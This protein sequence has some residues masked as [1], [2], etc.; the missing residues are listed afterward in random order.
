M[1]QYSYSLPLKPEELPTSIVRINDIWRVCKRYLLNKT[2]IHLDPVL[3]LFFRALRYLYA[4]TK[5]FKG[6]ISQSNKNKRKVFKYSSKS[7]NYNSNNK[8]ANIN[9][10]NNFFLSVNG[11]A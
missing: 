2:F 6:S 5:P 11:I 9:K 1:S 3:G 10:T 8:F 7:N 4:R